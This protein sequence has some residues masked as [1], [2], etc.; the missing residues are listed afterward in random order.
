MTQYTPPPDR[1]IQLPQTSVQTPVGDVSTQVQEQVSQVNEIRILLTRA[2]ALL[3]EARTQRNE[4][5]KVYRQISEVLTQVQRDA[6]E[7]AKARDKA[8]EYTQRGFENVSSSPTLDVGRFVDLLQDVRLEVRENVQLANLLRSEL[9]MLAE[10]LWP[11]GWEEVEQR[12]EQGTRVESPPSH[13]LEEYFESVGQDIV[14]QKGDRVIWT[15]EGKTYR[16]VVSGTQDEKG[17]LHVNDPVARKGYYVPARFLRL[18][19]NEEDEG[20]GNGPFDVVDWFRK[21]FGL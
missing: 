6:A 9:E 19:E 5:G 4:A 7:A 3:E 8:W 21:K 15:H 18:D 13:S 12:L 2:E 10:F 11:E 14:F 17:R 1:L 20:G 16:G